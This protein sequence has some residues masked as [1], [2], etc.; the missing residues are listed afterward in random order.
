M[1][2]EVKKKGLYSIYNFF[3]NINLNANLIYWKDL[4]FRQNLIFE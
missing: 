1:E 4:N 3:T 2:N